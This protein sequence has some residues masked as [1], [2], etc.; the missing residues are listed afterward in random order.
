MSREMVLRKRWF[1][2]VNLSLVILNPSSVILN[3]VKN[4]AFTLKI[5]AAENLE[6]S[7]HDKSEILRQKPQND[8]FKHLM[9]NHNE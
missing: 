8:S 7:M 3:E 5:N 2:I 9:A 1:V 4:L 6:M